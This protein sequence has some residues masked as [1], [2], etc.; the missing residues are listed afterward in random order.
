MINY[1]I[2]APDYSDNSGG[3]IALHVLADT[4][5]KLGENCLIWTGR[6][7]ESSSAKV[8]N[9]DVHLNGLNL[10]N[11]MVIYPEIIIGNPFNAKY[12][13]RWLLNSPGVCGGDGIYDDN[14][15][16][17]KFWD[18]FK[19]PDESKVKGNLRTFKAKLDTF[20]NRNE[21]REGQCF[22]VKKGRN[23]VL[24]KHEESA[25][26]IDKYVSDEYLIDVF[27][28]KEYFVSYDSIC[29]HLQQ[30]ALCGC[31]PIV[32]PDEGVSKEEFVEKSPI[33]RHGVAYGFEDIQW[34]KDTMGLLRQ[35]LANMELE[36]LDLVK[37]YIDDCYEHMNITKSY[38][39]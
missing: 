1:L 14:D 21:P 23:K 8:I 32:I 13:T 17:Y 16:V 33:N 27:N 7:F 11:T 24:D 15:L 25:L 36:T 26:N 19:A 34:A 10:E 18:Y 5:A 6:T 35:D 12:V 4:I 30:A 28:K 3:I 20:V 31:I 22:I 9:S 39:N 38:N 2:W 29:F 37:K